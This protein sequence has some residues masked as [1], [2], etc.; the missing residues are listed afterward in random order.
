LDYTFQAYLEYGVTNKFD[1]IATLPYKILV[2]Q[3]GSQNVLDT[4]TIAAGSLKGMGTAKFGLKYQLLNKGLKVATSI[5]TS[6]NTVSKALEKGLITGYDANSIG[7][8]LH[9]G[10]GFSKKLYTFIDVGV[11]KTSNNFSDYLEM[12]YELGYALRP[13][14]WAAFTLD[15]RTSFKDGSYQNEQLRQTGLYTNNQEYF[16]FGLKTSY[17]LKNKIGVTL[18]SFGAFNGNYVAK[19]A[20]FSLGVYKKW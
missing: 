4:N 6:F 8:Y 19:M 11:N 1:I 15:L 17:E 3:S 10:K 12:H 5:Q 14:F 16:A 13:S 18:A 2:T 20:T 9:F 7:F